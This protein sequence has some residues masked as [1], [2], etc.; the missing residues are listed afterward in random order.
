MVVSYFKNDINNKTNALIR[1]LAVRT[2]GCLRVHKLNEYLIE[3]IIKCLN[4]KHP[5]VRKSAI[6]SIPKLYV[7]SPDLLKEH[8]AIEAI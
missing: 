8:K 6:L 1:G 2:M 7:T 5:Y 4:D 3:P